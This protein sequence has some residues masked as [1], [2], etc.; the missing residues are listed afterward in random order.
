MLKVALIED[1]KPTSDQLRR[2]IDTSG[3][4]TQVSQ[5]FTRDT[6]E[7]AVTNEH[8]DVV[9]LDIE[10]GRKRNAGVA[11]IG[12]INRRASTVP[13]LVVSGMPADIYRG[14]RRR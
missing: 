14:V 4:E 5:W 8:Y 11:I 12:A 1:D 13:V 10:L 2:W 3:I 7:Q 9:I 6:A